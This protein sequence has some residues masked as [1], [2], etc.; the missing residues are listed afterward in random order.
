MPRRAPTRTGAA[1]ATTLLVAFA[2][3]VAA[4][5][6]AP[7]HP[8]PTAS[9]A[10]S[11]A[12]V[13][14]PTPPVAA[15]AGQALP[16]A[17][18]AM[19]WAGTEVP[20]SGAEL[21][22]PGPGA[23]TVSWRVP[24]EWHVPVLMYHAIATPAEATNALPGLVVSP[25]LFSD[26]LR[27]ARRAGWRTVTAGQL[28]RDMAAGTEP[29]PRTFVITIDDGREDGW[30]EAFPILQAFHFVATF[31][32]PSARIGRPG[33]LSA[34]QVIALSQA[35]MEIANH[36]VDH[37][38]LAHLPPAAARVEIADAQAAIAAL[39]GAPPASLAYPFGSRDRQVIDDV[40]AAGI[41][42][43]FTTVAGCRETLSA[44]LEAPRLRVSPA[45]TPARL[46]GEL[47]RCAAMP[48]WG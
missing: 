5:S 28:A 31:F 17:G 32:V 23:A 4:L 30:T 24:F 19:P 9:A 20:W 3:A 35:G 14:E 12:T 33:D 16:W 26:Q 34:A 46:V 44:R 15:M 37:V 10:G 18:G 8:G 29:P 36:S 7:S 43:A 40:A 25:S 6:L 2:F 39:L 42:V 38:P 1:I 47:G 27:A 21:P 45:T 11:T 41:G 48:A 22:G 13:G